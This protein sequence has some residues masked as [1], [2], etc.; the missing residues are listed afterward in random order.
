MCSYVSPLARSSQQIASSLRDRS[1][2][3][4]S[5]LSPCFLLEFLRA[6]NKRDKKSPTQKLMV[7]IEEAETSA[8][9]RF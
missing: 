1:P 6:H 2:T 4:S 7:A 3:Q 9:H 5:T 8:D